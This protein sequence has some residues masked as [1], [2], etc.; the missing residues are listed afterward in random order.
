MTRRRPRRFPP[1]RPRLECLEDRATPAS[2]AAY[3]VSSGGTVKV[4]KTFAQA[5]P[6][7]L[8]ATFNP[9]PGYTGELTLAT[10]DFTG[11]GVPDEVIGAGPG[12]GPRVAIFDGQSL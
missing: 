2:F 8:V 3:S 5:A 4:Y 7:Q 12:G 6:G 11:D 1:F 10:G 9:F